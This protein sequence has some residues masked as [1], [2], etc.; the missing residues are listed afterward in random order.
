MEPAWGFFKGCGKTLCTGTAPCMTSPSILERNPTAE[1]SEML[2]AEMHWDLTSPVSHPSFACNIFPSS[3]F[4]P[5]I[6]FSSFHLCL[7]P[8]SRG[9]V[10]LAYFNC[11]ALDLPLLFLWRQRR[12]PARQCQLLHLHVL[13]HALLELLS[14]QTRKMDGP[15]SG[16]SADTARLPGCLGGTPGPAAPHHSAQHTAAAAVALFIFSLFIRDFSTSPPPPSPQWRMGIL[17]AETQLTVSLD[18]IHQLHVAQL[19]TGVFLF[20]DSILKHHQVFL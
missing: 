3:F 2:L 19:G 10:F 4:S 20:L 14:E 7:L 6:F 15:A 12:A 13:P 8:A 5:S 17:A 18:L 1:H 11:Q 16:R 9:C